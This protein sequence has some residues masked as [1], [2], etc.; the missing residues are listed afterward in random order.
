MDDLKCCC[1]KCG[2]KKE[3]VC[4]VDGVPYCEDCFIKALGG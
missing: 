4:V 1:G 3:N 2:Q